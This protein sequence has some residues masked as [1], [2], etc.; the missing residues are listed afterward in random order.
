MVKRR[1]FFLFNVG[2]VLINVV[3]IPSWTKPVG[4][5]EEENP[6]KKYPGSCGHVHDHIF[7]YCRGSNLRPLA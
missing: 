7:S 1:V 2:Q 4:T 5:G 6:V 3:I